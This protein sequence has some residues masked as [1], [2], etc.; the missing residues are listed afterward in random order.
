MSRRPDTASGKPPIAVQLATAR[1][2]GGVVGGTLIAEGRTIDFVMTPQVAATF[3]GYLAE[4]LGA[5]AAP[6]P[7]PG[8]D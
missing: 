1:G 6:Q 2:R 4:A 8:D 3:A 5:L 7:K